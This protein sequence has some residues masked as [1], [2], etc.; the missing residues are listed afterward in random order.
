MSRKTRKLIWPLPG[1]ATLAIVAALAILVAVP[2]GITLAQTVSKGDPPGDLKAERH[3]TNT[4]MQINLSWTAPEVPED[5]TVADDFRVDVSRDGMTWELLVIDAEDVN[6]SSDDGIQYEHT[7]LMAGDMFYYRVFANYGTNPATSMVFSPPTDMV[8]ASTAMP[9]RPAAPNMINAAKATDDD[10]PAVDES[11][12]IIEVYWGQGTPRTGGATIGGY[13]IEYSTNGGS[14]WM[15]LEAMAPAATN[16]G[17]YEDDELAPGTTRAYRVSAVAQGAMGTAPVIGWP[18]A[19]D[20]AT[21]DMMTV[22]E[23]GAPDAPTGLVAVGGDAMIDLY[24]DKSDTV[25]SDLDVSGYKIERSGNYM[26]GGTTEVTWNGIVPDSGD[27]STTYTDMVGVNGITYW[28]RVSAIGPGGI[29]APSDIA[30]AITND[31]ASPPD[32]PDAPANLS[33]TGSNE[34]VKMMT[35]IV[36]IWE[37]ADVLTP[38][39]SEVD[40]YEVQ[41]YDREDG[42]WMD[43]ATVKDGDGNMVI[44]LTYPHTGLVGGTTLLYRV[45]AHNKEGFSP[46]SREDAGST[47]AQIVPMG[48]EEDDALSAEAMGTSAIMLEWEEPDENP[49]SPITGYSIEYAADDDGEP[50]NWMALV[51]DTESTDTMYTDMMDLSAGMTRHYRVYAVNVNV[52]GAHKR[53]PVSNMAMATTSDMPVDTAPGDASELSGT[54]DTNAKTIMLVWTPGENADFH[55]VAGIR[56]VDGDYDFDNIIYEDAGAEGS[57]T[58]DM[59]SYDNGT[60]RFAVVAGRGASINDADAEWSEVW[61]GAKVT[62]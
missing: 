32:V 44:D 9:M 30:Q 15:V 51:E 48:F 38:T 53:G 45:R 55:R 39:R 33:A 7:G 21:T 25:D 2:V 16:S 36:L 8:S 37:A 23:P 22:M 43:L 13:Q 34:S 28:Y 12:T 52:P 61:T 60:Y 59:S 42:D 10:D 11:E 35:D 47:G 24:W 57:Y 18:S 46:W 4:T 19:V 26:V 56:F 54:A 3:D 6:S 50:G 40:S 27:D 14:S 31:M 29:G 41:Y 58:V 20:S 5:E 62:Y 49:G 1:M 17:P